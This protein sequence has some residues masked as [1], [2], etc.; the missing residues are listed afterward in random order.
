M[1]DGIRRLLR[2]VR[3]PRGRLARPQEQRSNL[4]IEPLESERGFRL[5]GDLDIYTHAM[6]R[7]A[8]KPKL[9]GTL[10]VDI[11]GVDFIDES[12][13]S[14]LVS[15]MKRLH[16]H[17]GLLVLRNPSGQVL[18]VLDMTELAGVPGLTIQPDPEDPGGDD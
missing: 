2:R 5:S 13:L 1:S 12:G 15:A 6:L 10:V 11:A 18:K 4:R 16:E 3:P 17:G 8:L 7:D 14:V 9:H